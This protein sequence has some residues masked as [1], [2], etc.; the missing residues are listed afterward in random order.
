MGTQ[1]EPPDL[2]LPP[3][4]RP[5]TNSSTASAPAP[6]RSP[7]PP[8]ISSAATTPPSLRSPPAA[9]QCRGGQP[10][11]QLVAAG[12]HAPDSLR[13]TQ[14]ITTISRAPR[15]ATPRPPDA[16]PGP[17]VPDA[18]AARPGGT[19]EARG[20]NATPDKAAWTEHCAIGLMADAL[21]RAPHSP[22]RSRPRCWTRSP[23]RDPPPNPKR[24]L[25]PRPTLYP[26][27]SS[28]PRRSVPGRSAAPLDFG[29]PSREL[30]NAIVTGDSPALRALDTATA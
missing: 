5:T 13:L 25:P 3:L 26:V 20:G 10:R 1:P 11:A 2:T 22:S 7:T 28:V 23:K 4:G 8:T 29:P 6:R 17:R 24:I 14:L 19:P 12:A 30:V 16:A 9:R 27:I 21:G 15:N 18:A